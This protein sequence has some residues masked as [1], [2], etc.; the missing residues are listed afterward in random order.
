MNRICQC[1]GEPE[2]DH[3]DFVPMPMGCQCAPGG[4]DCTHR[5]DPVPEVCKSFLALS[6]KEPDMCKTCEHDKECHD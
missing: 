5:G 4:W 3:H 1:C 2:R 6:D